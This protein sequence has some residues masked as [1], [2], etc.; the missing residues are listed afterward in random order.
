MKRKHLVV[1]GTAA[2]VAFTAYCYGKARLSIPPGAKAV[3]D[4][5]MRK[6]LGTWHEIARFD[7][8]FEKDMEKVTATY[9]LKDNGDIKVDNRGFDTAKNKWK[10]SIGVAKFIGSDHV[11]RIKVSFF[12][13]FYSSYNVLSIDEDYQYALVVGNSKEYLW[14]LS[15]EKT[16][17]G[18][19]KEKYLEI[20]R[21]LGCE[22]HKLIWV[23]Q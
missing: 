5:D 17:P 16:M 11:G 6:Y 10:Q 20:A 12:K 4:F 2:A 9:S 15:R 13:P 3:T 8:R 21:G 7:Y 14:F 18:H 22:T 1:I 23:V 19:I